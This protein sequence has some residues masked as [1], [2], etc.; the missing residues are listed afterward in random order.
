MKI[1]KGDKV[2]VIAGDDKGVVAE[3]VA[4]LPR[5]NR[6]IVEGV[7]VVKKHCKPSNA[8]PDGGII[9]KELPISVSNVRLAE[10]KKDKKSAKKKNAKGAKKK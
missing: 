7:N 6:V 4:A 1:K 5:S 9:D 2:K 8:N 3:V 10:S